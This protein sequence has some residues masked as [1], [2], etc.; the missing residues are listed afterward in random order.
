MKNILPLLFVITLL[1]CQN[2]TDSSYVIFRGQLLNNTANTLKISGNNFE[3]E[4]FI[5]TNGVF[6]DT[7]FVQNNGY[8]SLRIGRES[9][10][11]Y[12][13]KG[14]S[15]NLTTDIEQFDEKLKYSGEIDSETLRLWRE[16]VVPLPIDQLR[17][18]RGSQ[19]AGGRRVPLK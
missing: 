18:A 10:P 7:L 12:L 4:V 13:M 11:I 5:T 8:Y 2:E 17:V 9:T 3:K 14:T 16:D 19:T 15:L 1:S 6:S